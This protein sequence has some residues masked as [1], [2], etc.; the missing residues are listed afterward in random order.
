MRWAFQ[1][2]SATYTPKK[3]LVRVVRFELTTSCAQGNAPKRANPLIR[4]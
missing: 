4:L 3:D 1:N 2:T